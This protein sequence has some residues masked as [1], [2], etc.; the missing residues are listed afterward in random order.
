MTAKLA[1][2]GRMRELGWNNARLARALGVHENAVRRLLSLRHGSRMGLVDE[3]L[4]EMDTELGIL[5]PRSRSV[6]R[7]A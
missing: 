6:R 2:Y 4:A 5:L 7:A 1:V 3:A